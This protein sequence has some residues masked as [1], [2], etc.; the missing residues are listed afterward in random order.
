[1]GCFLDGPSWTG[2]LSFVSEQKRTISIALR[3]SAVMDGGAGVLGTVSDDMDAVR[4]PTGASCHERRQTHFMRHYHR[5]GVVRNV[6]TASSGR[7][8]G[9][10]I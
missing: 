8:H 6:F 7:H 5:Y 9:A 3:I 10:E 4:M 1:M 2:S